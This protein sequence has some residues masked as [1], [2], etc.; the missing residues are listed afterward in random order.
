MELKQIQDYLFRD[1]GIEAVAVPVEIPAVPFFIRK[2]FALYKITALDRE[3]CLLLSQKQSFSQ[4][5][6]QE[7]ISTFTF[8]QNVSGLMPVFVFSAISKQERLELVRQKMAFLV[9]D[10]QMFIPSLG[11]DFSERIP[12]TAPPKDKLLRPAAQALIIQQILTGNLDGLTVN[13]ASAV[14]GYTAMGTLRAV[15]QLNDLGICKVTFDGYRKQLA[16]PTDRKSLWEKSKPFLRNP[17][18]KTLS[19]E[20]DSALTGFPFAGEFA[21]AHHSD[22]SVTRKTYALH[23]KD[24]SALLDEGKIRIAFASETGCA[25]I[26]VWSYTLPSWDGEVD[27]F[28]LGLSFSNTD[29][30]RI[31]IALLNLEEQRKW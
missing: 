19:V 3:L 4:H 15:N 29:D 16:F 13:Q 25:D 21:L 11:L 6:F 12:Q 17:V 31:K 20:D 1:L 2:Q 27:L 10:S 7:I 23:Q 5:K 30:A 22:L 8:V 28:S 18:K 14:M 26:Q 24:V 9:P